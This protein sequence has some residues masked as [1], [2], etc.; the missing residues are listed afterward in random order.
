MPSQAEENVFCI[1]FDVKP[2]EIDFHG[3]LSPYYFLV[4]IQEAAIHHGI[5]LRMGYHDMREMGVFWVL[6]RMRAVFSRYPKTLETGVVTTWVKR[7]GGLQAL[8]DFLVTD[9]EGKEIARATSSWMVLDMQTH[10]PKGFKDIPRSMPIVSQEMLSY[11]KDPMPKI[12]MPSIDTTHAVTYSDVDVNL[13]VNNLKYLAWLFDL[14]PFDVYDRMQIVEVDVQFLKET[15]YGEI[16]RLA[17]EEMLQSH[18]DFFAS[19][20]RGQHG[21]KE[22]LLRARIQMK[23]RQ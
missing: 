13:H 1:P 19:I 23:P 3:L 6:T 2:H 10:R 15:H 14:F 18:G 4:H 9:S 8:R 16:L 11:S 12:S 17:V 5:S 7:V 22:Q 21:V 20:E